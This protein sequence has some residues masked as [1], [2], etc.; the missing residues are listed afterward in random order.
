MP[1]HR[2]LTLLCFS[3]RPLTLDRKGYSYEQ[4]NLVDICLGLIEIVATE[5]DNRQTNLTVRIAIFAIQIYLLEP[6]LSRGLL[7]KAKLEEFL[8]ARFAAIY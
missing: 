6:T 1:T 8:L 2:V 4:D 5:D 3:I 7:D